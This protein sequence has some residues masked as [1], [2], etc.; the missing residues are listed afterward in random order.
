MPAISSIIGIAGLVI[1]AGSTAYSVHASNEAADEQSALQ[2]KQ[3]QMEK[4]AAEAEAGQIREKSRRVRAAQ[5]AGLASAGVSLDG[6]TPDALLAET[7][8]LSEQDAMAALSGGA[9]RASLLR[10]GA[11]ITRAQGNRAAIAGSINGAATLI[12]GANAL[13]KA[14]TKGRM[15]DLELNAGAQ[16]MDATARP[17]YGASLLG[18]GELKL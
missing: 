17:R 5:R 18:P 8:R 4:T 16:G 2:D 6:G 14:G 3:A 12:N 7:T 10:D 9:N 15:T 11:D 13:N 1:A